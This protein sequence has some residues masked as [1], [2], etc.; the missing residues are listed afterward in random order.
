MSTAVTIGAQASVNNSSNSISKTEEYSVSDARIIDV[1]VPAATS[2]QLVPFVLAYAGIKIISMQAIWANTVASPAD[3]TLE[4]N[5]SSSPAQTFT[6][7]PNAVSDWHSKSA[8]TNPITTNITALYATNPHAT[9]ACTLRIVVA[10][11]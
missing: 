7:K 6:L 1:S 2:D 9:E 8:F 11:L 10:N 3:L 5:S 4:T